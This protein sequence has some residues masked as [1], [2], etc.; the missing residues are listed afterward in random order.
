MVLAPKLKDDFLIIPSRSLRICSVFPFIF[1]VR[2]CNSHFSHLFP[3]TTTSQ[4]D[5]DYCS[6]P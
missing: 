1:I 2:Y 4:L 6:A 3:W 5:S